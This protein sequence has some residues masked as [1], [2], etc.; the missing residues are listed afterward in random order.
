MLFGE[1]FCRVVVVVVVVTCQWILANGSSSQLTGVF[2][3][4]LGGLGGS[5]G[6]DVEGGAK[7]VKDNVI[8]GLGGSG[9]RYPGWLAVV[10]VMVSDVSPIASTHSVRA[11]A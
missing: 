3:L 7:G 9:G 4:L 6:L 11:L 1:S 5:G 10:V 8:L 2:L